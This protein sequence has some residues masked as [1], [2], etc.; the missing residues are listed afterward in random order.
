MAQ[1]FMAMSVL[2]GVLAVTIVG[3]A[4]KEFQDATLVSATQISGVPQIT[5][6]G[7]YPTVET[8]LAQL[9]VAAIVVA[10]GVIQSRKA[11]AN[12]QSAVA[13]TSTAHAEI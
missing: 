12:R 11:K 10:L 2:L 8:L 6:L 3:G 7:I 5:L 4:V 9:V 1:L 13:Q